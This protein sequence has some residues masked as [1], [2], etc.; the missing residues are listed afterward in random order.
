MTFQEALNADRVGDLELAA[1]QYEMLLSE[2]E[3][4]IEL[5]L[6]LSILYWQATDP[7]L[8]AAKKLSPDFFAKAG[9]RFPELL[10]EAARRYP[11]R[12]E[13]LF[14]TRYVAW[15]DLGEPFGLEDCRE[16]L[17]A[18]PDCLVPAMGIFGITEGKEAVRE[19]IELLRRCHVEATTRARYVASVI[20]GVLHRSTRS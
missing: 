14:W 3:S 11:S 18:D 10:A 13:P 9:V 20:E 1:S 8:A 2:G 15:A 4:D 12:S 5:L 19:A 16:L 17:R 7:G 6:N